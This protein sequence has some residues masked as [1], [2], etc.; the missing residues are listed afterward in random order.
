[1]K[2]YKGLAGLDFDGTLYS[3]RSGFSEKN[4]KALHSLK[5]CG[6]CRAIVTGRNLAS[7]K[8]VT[9]SLALPIDYLIFSTGAGILNW[10]TGELIH[11][12]TLPAPD[13]NKIRKV[14]IDEQLDFMIQKEI[15]ENHEFYY[16][17]HNKNNSDFE[18]RLT[19]YNDGA[20]PLREMPPK[21]RA[22][23]FVAILPP[24]K[25]IP[26]Q[27]QKKLVNY[28]LIRATSPMDHT[29]IWLEIF[30]ENVNKGNGI[31]WL[32]NYLNLENKL[33]MSIGNDYNDLAMLHHTNQAWIVEN[34]PE[35]LKKVFKTTASCED[36]GVS[37][38]IND[39][40]SSIF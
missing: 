16:Y 40:L 25:P 34:G 7:F 2:D 11:S 15:P 38:A 13:V 14:L 28:S 24:G 29:S 20:L 30:P 17:R 18:A 22:S 9:S 23:Q 31:N 21:T 39:W 26:E 4:R 37:T 3:P 19:L 35:E 32:Q 33:S 36:G 27:V 10:E 5:E 1:M 8:K 12:N 6:I